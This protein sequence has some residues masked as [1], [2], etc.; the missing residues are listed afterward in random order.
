M[1]GLVLCVSWVPW[2]QKSDF[3]PFVDLLAA[4]FFVRNA[5]AHNTWFDL[6]HHKRF[7]FAHHM[8]DLLDFLDILDFLDFVFTI[9][10][11]FPP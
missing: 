9:F 6:A 1:T 5:L 8:P 10:K 7:D 4:I 3:V 2:I 11:F